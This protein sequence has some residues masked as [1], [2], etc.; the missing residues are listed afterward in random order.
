MRFGR[1]DLLLKKGTVMEKY[2][3]ARLVVDAIANCDLG[4]QLCWNAQRK[5]KIACEKVGV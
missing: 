2:P 1:T 5:K 4:S 3:E